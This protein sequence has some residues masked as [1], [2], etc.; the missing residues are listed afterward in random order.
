MISRKKVSPI[1]KTT[2]FVQSHSND[3]SRAST[4]AFGLS[5][6]WASFDLSDVAT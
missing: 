5:K 1:E 6:R 2:A 3:F 4:R